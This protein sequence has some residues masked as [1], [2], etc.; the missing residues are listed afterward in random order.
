MLNEQSLIKM[1]VDTILVCL[2]VKSISNAWYLNSSPRIRFE[3]LEEH[4]ETLF[5]NQNLIRIV[6]FLQS[7]LLVCV[8]DNIFFQPDFNLNIF[9]RFL[10]ETRFVLA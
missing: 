8:H 4:S 1:L 10:A 2:E 9:I 7:E 3:I 5:W 6:Y